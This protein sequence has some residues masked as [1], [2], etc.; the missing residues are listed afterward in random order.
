MQKNGEIVSSES[1]ISFEKFLSEA[2]K[3]YFNAI[4]ESVTVKQAAIKLE[5]QPQTL[6]NWKFDLLN[7]RIPKAIGFLRCVSLQ[8]FRSKLLRRFLTQR[9]EI[10]FEKQFENLSKI[11]KLGLPENMETL[12]NI[13]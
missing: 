10:N 12:E 1:Y 3:K 4:A 5:I 13:E 7:R 11:E 6:Y 9:V 8:K 2:D